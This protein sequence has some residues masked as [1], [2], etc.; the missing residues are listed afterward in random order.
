MINWCSFVVMLCLGA[1]IMGRLSMFAPTS[2]GVLSLHWDHHISAQSCQTV[3]WL[4]GWFFQMF[5]FSTQWHMTWTKPPTHLTVWICHPH[6]LTMHTRCSEKH[7][8]WR[9]TAPL[10]YVY[11][12]KIQTGVNFKLSESHYS[13]TPQ[14]GMA[15]TY[16]KIAFKSRFDWVDSWLWL[17]TWVYFIKPV[18]ERSAEFWKGPTNETV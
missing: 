17:L 5:T 8:Y 12:V 7:S 14:A 18:Q 11:L 13:H 16:K 10:S 2:C 3:S 4:W 9:N 15:K 1:C 6:I